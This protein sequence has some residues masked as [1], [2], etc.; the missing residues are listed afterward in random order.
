MARIT[1]TTRRAIE[2]PT[3][4]I[5]PASGHL[6]TTNA[7][8]RCP[9]N[10]RRIEALERAGDVQ[11][12]LDEEPA[13]LPAAALPRPPAAARLIEGPAPSKAAVSSPATENS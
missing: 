1:N 6:E 10:Y 4:H 12:D 2:L 5:I 7:L 3:R 13:A 8:I 11:V 9:D